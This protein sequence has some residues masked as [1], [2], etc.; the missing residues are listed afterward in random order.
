MELHCKYQPQCRSATKTDVNASTKSYV[1]KICDRKFEHISLF[2]SHKKEHEKVSKIVSS[3]FFIFS[4]YNFCYLCEWLNF[5]FLI[6]MTVRIRN[7]FL[8]SHFWILQELALWNHQYY[9][10]LV[11]KYSFC[12]IHVPCWL[13][14]LIFNIILFI[15]AVYSCI[16]SWIYEF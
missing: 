8:V 4:S 2:L 15:N 7:V 16:L 3:S 1:C 13:K 10:L 14:C 11:E 5:D 6:S 9:F 12:P